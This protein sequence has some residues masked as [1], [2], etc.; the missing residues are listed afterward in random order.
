MCTQRTSPSSSAT[1][2]PC[3][4]TSILLAAA[5]LMMSSSTWAGHPGFT[6]GDPEVSF[7][8]RPAVPVWAAQ[9]WPSP[10][11]APDGGRMVPGFRDRSPFLPLIEFPVTSEIFAAGPDDTPTHSC[12]FVG[13]YARDT[14][15]RHIVDANLNHSEGLLPVTYG[16][17]WLA[18]DLDSDGHVELVLQ[19]GDSGMGGNGYLDILSAPD[20]RLRTRIVLP[21]MKVYFHPVAID[22]DGDSGVEI[23]LTPSSLSGDARAML[24]DY[25]PVAQSFYIL[26]DITAPSGT[27]G[28]TA[29]ADFDHDGR[30]EFLTGSSSGY[31]V[32]ELSA[33]VL[34]DRGVIGLAERG[35]WATAVRPVPDG[36]PHAILG[37]SS[38]DAGYRYY[39]MR[40]A[41]DN[42]FT[43]A[44][45]FQEMT[46][47]AGL[48][49][50]FA[51]DPDRDGMDEFVVSLYP[52]ARFY[53][54]DAAL[55][56]YREFWSLDQT[57]EGT[58]LCWGDCDLDKDHVGEWCFVN[59]MNVF[60]AYEDQGAS[61]VVCDA[62]S[63][64]RPDVLTAWPNPFGDGTRLLLRAP[65]RARSSHAAASAGDARCQVVDLL[66]PQGRCL[67]T[68]TLGWG[69][70]MAWDG[71]DRFGRPVAAGVYCL[72]PRGM[73]DGGLRLVR[74]E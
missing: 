47:Y 49:S 62:A 45:V 53:E 71:C 43:V 40:P 41:G 16:Q 12:F 6:A 52:T 32:F 5:L 67:R 44:Q 35:A 50:S 74:I 8:D 7:A 64:V 30:M 69:I 70:E 34:V 39:L 3:V 20:W 23:F 33:N 9:G 72:R 25:D 10:V 19:R 73:A 17:T 15:V 22:V 51:S 21:G 13:D 4:R 54:W 46:G 59:H 37:Y 27:G 42:T 65:D 66:D 61:T 38:F 63:D 56:V 60:R 1:S 24:I 2:R 14:I 29:A 68:W 36:T 18:E 28:P 11:V 48:H 57:V 55:D 58:V 31:H 26:S